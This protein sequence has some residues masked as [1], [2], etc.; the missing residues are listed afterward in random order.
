VADWLLESVARTPNESAAPTLTTLG[1]IAF[2]NLS[3]E[4]ELSRDGSLE[5]SCRPE[6]LDPDTRAALF[7]LSAQPLEVVLREGSAVRFAGPVWS[8]GLQGGTLSANCRGL[9]AFTRY[10]QVD[11]DTGDLAFSA[12]DQYAIVAALIDA[13]QALDYGDYGLD[14]S[15][16]GSSGVT[17]DAPYLAAERHQVYQRIVELSERINGFDVWVTPDRELHLA[18]ERGSDLSDAVFLDLRNITSGDEQASVAAGDVASEAWGVGTSTGDSA[19]TSQQANAALRATFGRCGVSDT[20]DSVSGQ[21]TLDDH[22][23]RLLDERSSM[24]VTPGP[25]LHP[26]RDAGVGDFDVGDTISYIFATALGTRA[27]AYRV[28]KKRV[29]VDEGGSVNMAVEFGP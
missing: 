20:F 16:V 2:T 10:M 18:A 25:G 7:D 15:Q 12:T 17:R 14:T 13:W 8:W 29:Q 11:G 6:R 22:T 24:L 19:Y 1:P 9:L 27:R 21:G 26:V 5:F 28:V 3:Y 23:G 4:D